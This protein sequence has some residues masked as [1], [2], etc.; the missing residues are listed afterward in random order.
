M[1]LKLNSLLDLSPEQVSLSRQLVDKLRATDERWHSLNHQ[2]YDG[3]KYQSIGIGLR[4]AGVGALSDYE[5][6][7]IG[8]L[9]P[10]LDIDYDS[11]NYETEFYKLYGWYDLVMTGD[12]KKGWVERGLIYLDVKLNL[13]FNQIAGII[14]GA[15]EGAALIE[16][17]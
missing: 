2:V 4:L 5:A 10:C 14:E 16:I 17:N 1:I 11:T 6:S 3:V 7:L 12:D 8:K 9:C 15:L 13:T